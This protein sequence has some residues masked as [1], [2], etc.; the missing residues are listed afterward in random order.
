MSLIREISELN[1]H[2]MH[3]NKE[4]SLPLLLLLFL[5]PG[6]SLYLSSLEAI[7]VVATSTVVQDL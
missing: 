4:T 7:L 5:I 6:G 1:T 2:D 3:L